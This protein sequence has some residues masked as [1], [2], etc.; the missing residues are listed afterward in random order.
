MDFAVLWVWDG[1]VLDSS[2]QHQESWERMSRERGLPL[3]DGHFEAGFGKRNQVII[4]KILGW[5]QDPQEVERLGR[6]KEALYR[7]ILQEPG[8]QPEMLPG[9]RTLMADLHH[10]GVKH[11]IGSSTERANLDAIIE[12]FEIGPYFSGIVSG[13]DVS[14]GKPHPEVFVKASEIAGLPS[15]QCLVIEDSVHGIEAGLAAG[16]KVLAVATTHSVEFLEKSG[17]TWVVYRLSDI[18]ADELAK[19]MQ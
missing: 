8:F 13:D 12:L 16:C 2:K 11:V 9:A 18:S 4:P 19:R 17:A 7:S 1:V 10:L 5:A 15:E 6:E 14:Q 3:P